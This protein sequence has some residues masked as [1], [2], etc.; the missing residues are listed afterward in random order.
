MPAG[1][2][3]RR[4]EELSRTEFVGARVERFEQDGRLLFIA[5]LRRG[6]TPDSHVI[7]VGCGALRAGYWLIHFLD[8]GHYHGIEPAQGRLDAARA[9]LLEPGL[10]QS[11]RPTFANNADFDLS[12]FG[13][14]PDFVL[15]RSIWSHAAKGQIVALLD[16]FRD[17]S[18]LGSLLL[19]SYHPAGAQPPGPPIRRRLR[20]WWSRLTSMV[21]RDGP[22][23]ADGTALSEARARRRGR[24]RRQ[25]AAGYGGIWDLPDYQGDSWV[26]G[27]RGQAAHRLEFIEEQ[28][29]LRGLTARETQQDG[30][31]TQVWLEIGW[32]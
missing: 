2:L 8:P 14:V 6:L 1:D 4:A 30:F 5:L 22:E 23:G 28:C 18:R 24:R 12:G 9:T 32:A 7:D 10:E 27:D 3:Q 21:D 31:G 11:R 29:R 25:R 15:A 13:V 16:S 20:A 17:V 19:A 26:T